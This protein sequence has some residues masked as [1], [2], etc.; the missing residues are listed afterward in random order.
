MRRSRPP[1]PNRF[2]RAVTYAIREALAGFR[3]APLLMT[4]SVVSI[5]LSLFVVGLFGLAAHNIRLAIDSIEERVEVV[6]YLRDDATEEQIRQAQEEART[7]APVLDVHFVSKTEALA[8]AVRDLDEFRE[9]YAELDVNPLPASIEVRLRPGHRS[10]QAVESVAQHFFGYTF[11]ED[12]RFGREW[13][14]KVFS[15]RRVAAGGAGILGGA[16]AAV[17]AIIIAAAIRIAVFARR[18]EISIMQMVGATNGFIQRPFLLEGSFAGILG[19]VI[20]IG[21]TW[22]AFNVINATLLQVAWVP[23][24]W[25]PLGVLAGAVLGFASSAVAVRRHLRAV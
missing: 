11:V 12:V 7:L 10:P 13:L 1:S 3:R 19:G 15:L 18:E 9:I 5:A 23:A 6:A 4:I 2:H 21:L 8:T 14:D 22:G 20:A 24:L 16:F 25:P 17:A